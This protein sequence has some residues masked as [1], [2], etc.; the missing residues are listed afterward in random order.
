[1]NR[2]I[3]CAIAYAIVALS[4]TTQAAQP[5]SETPSAQLAMTHESCAAA[6]ATNRARCLKPA[7]AAVD[8]SQGECLDAV[9]MRQRVCMI[10]VLEAL[11][12]GL[13]RTPAER[14]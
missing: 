7:K 3:L 5:V 9:N 6:A 11:H 14:N 4:S 12:P 10:E 1:M 2:M 13:G 8:P